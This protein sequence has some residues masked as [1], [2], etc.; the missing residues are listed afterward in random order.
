[1]HI[2][3]VTDQ[4]PDSL[5]GAQVS[6]RLQQRFLER[7]G[8]TVSI[9]APKRLERTQAMTNVTVL[10]RGN[11]EP[12]R[13]VDIG[14]P[15]IPLT[16]QRDYGASWPGRRSARYVERRM[17][18]LPSVDIVHVQGDFWGALLGYRLARTLGVPVVHTMH[19][20]L[21]VGTR[22]VTRAAPAVF[23]SLRAARRMMLGPV[24]RVPGDE[25]RRGAWR[26]L[27]D[28]AGEADAVVVPSHHF[29]EELRTRGVT[30]RQ[31]VEVI[32]SG[33]D[34]DLLDRLRGEERDANPEPVLV[35]SGRMS[36][37]KRVRPLIEAF[38]RMREPAQLVLIGGGL[39]ADEVAA[40]VRDA[41]VR[42]RVRMTGHLPYE[43]ALREIR[44]ADALV[45]TSI[46][47]ET[48]GMTPYEATALGTPTVFSDPKIHRELDVAPSWIVEDPSV[49]ALAKTLNIVATEVVG[50]RVPDVFAEE[51]RQSHRTQQMLSVYERVRSL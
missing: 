34:D 20:N 46:G 26:Y 12:R 32:P 33:I 6:I 28:L 27:A 41:G 38:I 48:Q 45:Q 40:R 17:T 42:D 18:N 13:G 35:W 29:A 7:E 14:L 50:L 36:P 10:H 8:H 44:G 25:D 5:G 31:L 2:L 21:D 23:A 49:E 15:A 24:L 9:V 51:M 43:H 47:F 4:H 30:G 22:E 1:M 37:E 3:I 39:E 11:R 19:N 16:R